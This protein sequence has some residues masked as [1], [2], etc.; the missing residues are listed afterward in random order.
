M[1]LNRSKHNTDVSQDDTIGFMSHVLDRHVIVQR[2]LRSSIVRSQPIAR[3]DMEFPFVA[4]LPF[5]FRY[6]N[7]QVARRSNMSRS[8]KRYIFSCADIAVMFE[9]ILLGDDCIERPAYILVTRD[10][11]LE[12]IDASAST[13]KAG[14]SRTAYDLKIFK[15][16]IPQVLDREHY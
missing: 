13:A 6:W 16:F 11:R 1:F 8:V 15:I 7:L 4:N 5:G 3:P 10:D 14:S 9:H 2:Y 12:M